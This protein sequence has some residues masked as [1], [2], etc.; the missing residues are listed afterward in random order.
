[1]YQ[2]W[3]SSELNAWAS[4]AIFERVWVIWLMSGFTTMYSTILWLVWTLASPMQALTGKGGVV[5]SSDVAYDPLVLDGGLTS[6]CYT[7]MSIPHT[8]AWYM[9]F[10]CS[11]RFM[12]AP[13]LN[14]LGPRHWY[15]L[16]I[17]KAP[18]IFHLELPKLTR[19]HVGRI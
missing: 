13:G 6:T 19:R 2:P 1:M 8:R 16:L 14:I 11:F 12:H 18:K 17:W 5:V 9:F 3:W 10:D 15:R 4:T 7:Y